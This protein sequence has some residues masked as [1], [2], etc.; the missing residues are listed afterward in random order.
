MLAGACPQERNSERGCNTDE[1]LCRKSVAL[2]LAR[3]SDFSLAQFQ[4]VAVWRPVRTL[5]G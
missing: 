1:V 3:G 5:G 2:D 4:E